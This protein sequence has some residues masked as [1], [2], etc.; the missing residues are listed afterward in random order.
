MPKHDGEY[1]N[2][3]PK[4]L[5]QM[6]LDFMEEREHGLNQA[7]WSISN[8]LTTYGQELINLLASEYNIRLTRYVEDK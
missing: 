3:D 4:L 6:E 1:T 7:A 8:D 2:T 5:E